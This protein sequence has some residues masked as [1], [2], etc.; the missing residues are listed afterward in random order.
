MN[1]KTLK[2][3]S[4]RKMWMYVCAAV[5]MS[6]HVSQVCV[7]CDCSTDKNK[8]YFCM[9]IPTGMSNMKSTSFKVKCN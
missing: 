3:V 1:I 7:G 8:T 4:D 6:D 5:L 2:L 9:Y